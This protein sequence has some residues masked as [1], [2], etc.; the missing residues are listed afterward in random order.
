MRH[1][2]NHQVV[3]SQAPETGP[4]ATWLDGLRTRRADRDI[5]VRRSVGGF[6]WQP[7]GTSVDGSGKKGSI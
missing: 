2:I 5:P 7:V 1:V 4:L 3:L 6:G